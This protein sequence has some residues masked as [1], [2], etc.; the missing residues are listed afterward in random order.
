MIYWV[1]AF[2]ATGL[3][4]LSVHVKGRKLK[5]IEGQTIVYPD[6]IL[7]GLSFLVYFIPAAVRYGIGQ[8]Y[9]YTYAPT[10]RWIAN[11]DI[12]LETHSLIRYNEWGFT[13]LNKAIA[14][15]TS[16]YQWLFVITALISLVLVY[17]SIKKDSVSIPFSVLML[18]L[19]SYYLASYN[20]IR[21]C[22][23]I[24]IF[25]YSL[26]YV[27]ERKSVQ[28]F[29]CAALATTMHTISII[30]FP[31]YFLGNVKLKKKLYYILPIAIIGG[32]AVSSPIVI[33]IISLTRFSRNISLGQHYNLFLSA[34][35][36]LVYY[37]T[38]VGFDEK[39]TRYRMYANALLI[40]SCCIGVSSFTGA[41]DRLI[42][43]YYYINFLSIPHIFKYAK[44]G[45]NAK[46]IKLAIIVVLISLWIFE[47][48]YYDQFSVLPYESIIKW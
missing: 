33:R 40:A 3:A 5:V 1:F 13:V 14:F 35:V 36:L 25:A 26:K 48:I 2:I 4:Y 11:G 19:G 43:A 23:A 45:K 7:F 47:H 8:D 41:T 9:F 32:L 17:K 44:W 34:V 18:V 24:A 22:I 37:A 31:F 29:I 30:Y 28:Y 15:F 6:K 27:E 39:D 38:I 46:L 16:D 21:Q 12:N 10:F 42:Y 20:F